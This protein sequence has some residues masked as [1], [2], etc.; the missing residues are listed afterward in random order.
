MFSIIIPTMQKCNKVLDMLIYELVEEPLVGEIIIIDNSQKGFKNYSNGKIKIV[1]PE[2][3]L[4]VNPAWNSGIKLAKYD[5]IGILNDDLIIPKN[6]FRQIYYFLTNNKN[7]GLIGLDSTVITNTDINSFVK[8][9]E[10]SEAVFQELH[11]T[12]DTGYWGSA[13]FGQKEN[14][15]NIPEN[16]KIWC[17]DN[18]LLSANKNR[19]KTNFEIKN[20]EIKH[21]GSATCENPEVTK[22]RKKDIQN[23]AKIDENFKQHPDYEKEPT[24]LQKIFSIKNEN[25]HKVYRLLGIKIKQKLEKPFVYDCFTFYNEFE[26]LDLRLNI[27]DK[28]VDK[29]I[30]VEANKTHTGKDK[31]FYF[32]E[33]KEKFSKFLHKIIHIKVDDFPPLEESLTDKFNNK[34]LYENY[35]RDAIM[36]GLS[37]ADENDIVIISDCDE[38]PNPKAIIKYK[39]AKSKEIWTLNSLMMY[40][41]LNCINMNDAIWKKTKIGRLKNILNPMQNL[42]E[43]GY[44][45]NSKKGL[46]TYFRFCNGKEI[47]DGGWHF[48]YIGD[49]KKIL[50]KINSIA[51]QEY[52]ISEDLTEEKVSELIKSGQDILGRNY[53]YTA[54]KIDKNFPEYLRKNREKYQKLILHSNLMDYTKYKKNLKLK[55]FIRNIFSIKNIY[56]ENQ[57]CKRITIFGIR[58]TIV[59]KITSKDKDL[60]IDYVLNKQLDTSNY[61]K[62]TDKPYICKKN[63]PKLISFYLPQYHSFPENDEWFGR[64]FSEWSNVA[65]AVPQYTGHYQP[66]LP[67]DV[68]FYNLETTDIM[69]RQIEL[70]KMYG[71]Y[72]FSFYYYWFSGKKI[73]E[74]PIE[75]FLKDKSLDMPFFIFWANEH[76]TRLWGNGAQNEILYE[77]KLHESD[78]K[79]FMD[80]ILPYMKDNRYIKLNNKPLLI[81]CNPQLY[82]LEIFTKFIKDIR[83]IAKENGF[84]DLH[85]MTLRKSYMIKQN[86]KKTLREYN[87]D[88]MMEFI[89][90]D[91][92]GSEFDLKSEKIMNPKFSGTC[93]DVEKYIKDKKY[94]FETNCRLYKGC[95]PHWD[96]T[97]RKCYK[98]AWI[99]ESTPQLYKTWLKDIINWTKEHNPPEEQFVF[100]NAWNEW[101]EGAHL[102]PDQKYGYAY[103]QATKEALEE[104][105]SITNTESEN[106][107]QI[108]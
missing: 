62:I 30:L 98:K 73:M 43:S 94:L 82:K 7:V 9:P 86:L 100:I 47:S 83:K 38:I 55:R 5:C 45:S 61:V 87:L 4:Y 69:K 71:I 6:L 99:F 93:Y 70:A 104:T 107:L 1:I 25:K 28:Y 27:L 64:G 19:G 58:K 67:I 37:N 78:A 53:K 63:T 106:E 16:I 8:Y 11:K 84:D 90:G 68:G 97:A 88:A 32:E 57:K 34:W 91:V 108:N 22:I 72:G 36:R 44:Y 39:K 35:Q 24:F 23:Y 10:E 17:G 18:Y 74:K 66:H 41:Y 76:W 59:P 33:N 89:P 2:N 51:D 75:A 21:L 102:E 40:Y 103:L 96:N 12:K 52:N 48:S 95:F 13:I 56:K 92:G 3:N 14:Y 42:E 54:I 79:K 26:I 31:P 80:D 81:I 46:P 15:H 49:V 20:I 65:K 77:Q 60:Y 50:Q 105:T 29:F 85:I 101:A